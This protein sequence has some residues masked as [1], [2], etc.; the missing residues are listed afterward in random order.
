MT[1]NASTGAMPHESV[2]AAGAGTSRSGRAED[3]ARRIE[4]KFSR[5]R[6][7]SV[8]SEI[9]RNAGRT[10]VAV[11]QETDALVASA[12]DLDLLRLRHR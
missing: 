5:Y 10:P 6:E 1:Q 9:N 3:E 11:D 4:R 7:E 12:L 2:P 8:V